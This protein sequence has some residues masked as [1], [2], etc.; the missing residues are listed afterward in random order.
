[1]SKAESQMMKGVAILLMI[2]LHL[3]NQLP[4]VDECHNFL[5]IDGLPLVYILSRATNPVAFFLILGGYGLYKVNERGDKHRWSRVLKLFIHY[6]II[7]L[8]F[9]IVGHSIS[10]EKYPGTLSTILANITSFHTTY[11]GEMWF[12]FPYVILSLL[13]PLIFR[14]MKH[15]KATFI[16]LGTLFIQLCTSY[17]ISKYGAEY[18]YNNLWV[19]NP[20]LVL[21][22]LFAFSLGAVAA[23]ERFF[24]KAKSKGGKLRYINILKWGGVIVLVTVNCVFK[25]NFFY[26]F[27]IITLLT[28]TPMPKWIGVILTKLGNQSMNMWMIHSWFCYYLFHH[29]IYSFT[30]PLL[31]FLVLTIISYGCSLIVNTIA[32]PIELRLMSRFEV[33][34]KPIL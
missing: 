13:A 22:L 32:K 25:Y 15:F 23:R 28:L 29:F 11:N 21:H 9:V 33:K 26:A 19:Y 31:I 1:M 6:W 27:L 14:I 18:L 20:L 7:L 5:Y 17:C 10:P 24:E 16:V 4:N 12:L 8:L 34:A 2:F 30:Y 3:F